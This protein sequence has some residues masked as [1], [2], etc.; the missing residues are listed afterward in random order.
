MLRANEGGLIDLWTDRNIP[1]GSR[2]LKPLRSH[3]S[4]KIRLGLGGLSGAFVVLAFGCS[5]SVFVFILELVFNCF[6][7]N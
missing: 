7:Y 6:Q 3:K 5:L 1:D 2:C 4:D